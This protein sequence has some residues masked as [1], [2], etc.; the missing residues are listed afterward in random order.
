MLGELPPVVALPSNV[1]EALRPVPLF[2]HTAGLYEAPP[3]SPHCRRGSGGGEAA[4]M[5][6][7][8]GAA[9]LPRAD[10]RGER[11]AASA[12]PRE[13]PRGGPQPSF[14][15]VGHGMETLTEQDVDV[16][17]K[18]LETRYGKY[19]AAKQQ[20]TERYLTR[21]ETDVDRFLATHYG[22]GD[23]DAASRFGG[24]VASF[25][26]NT[27]VSRIPSPRRRIDGYGA[28]PKGTEAAATASSTTRGCESR[29]DGLP[30]LKAS[31][32]T[33]NAIPFNYLDVRPANMEAIAANLVVLRHCLAECFAPGNTVH[34]SLLGPIVRGVW[35]Q[36]LRPLQKSAKELLEVAQ[37]NVRPPLEYLFLRRRR[38]DAA[39][40]RERRAKY[41]RVATALQDDLKYLHTIHEMDR[42]VVEGQMQAR[43]AADEGLSDY[44][45]VSGLVLSRLHR[46]ENE[47]RTVLEFWRSR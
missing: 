22:G 26:K 36:S 33:A 45:P 5:P 10:S 16:L 32:Y 15:F 7:R 3:A 42:E 18:V 8:V 43:Q 12:S 47:H 29:T 25:I 31:S 13:A 24:G 9:P 2:A 38:G 6:Q 34:K 35:D 39:L 20:S 28:R 14:A 23:D 37:Q 44:V 1:A 11:E 17:L 30:T 4:V 19:Q 40:W 27:L 21:I 41:D 46:L